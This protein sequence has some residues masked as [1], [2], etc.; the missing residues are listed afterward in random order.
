[1][2]DAHAYYKCQHKI[3]E[4]SY[5]KPQ[6]DTSKTSK[7]DDKLDPYDEDWDEEEEYDE[8]DEE[9]DEED[10]E[11][12]DEDDEYDEEDD[13]EEGENENRS[14][15]KRT[16]Q[17]HGTTTQIKSSDQH[18]GGKKVLVEPLTEEECLMASPFA[19]GFDLKSKK[20]GMITKTPLHVVFE[21]IFDQASFLSIRSKRFRG[22]TRFS[23]IWCY[24]S[25]Q[26]MSSK[27]V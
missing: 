22:M 27:R 12:Y 6:G 18:K 2:I 3:P 26:R 19:K 7:R 8:E 9:Y 1:M 13:E 10:E 15:S 23:R 20:W 14:A 16:P 17:E 24:Q 25:S 5:G 4:G 21:L 11:E